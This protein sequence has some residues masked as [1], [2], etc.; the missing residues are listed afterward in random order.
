MDS[1]IVHT[2]IASAS[3]FAILVG[4][5][6]GGVVLAQA[7]AFSCLFMQLMIA[8]YSRVCSAPFV[9]L[10]ICKVFWNST[11]LMSHTWCHSRSPVLVLPSR[12]GHFPVMDAGG[13]PFPHND[14]AS[15]DAGAKDVTGTAVAGA[16][17]DPTGGNS[18]LGPTSAGSVLEHAIIPLYGMSRVP[19]SHRCHFLEDLLSVHSAISESRVNFH[20]CHSH[21][22]GVSLLFPP[23]LTS[24]QRL[25]SSASALW[26]HSLSEGSFSSSDL[27]PLVASLY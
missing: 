1:L 8:C 21:D 10:A 5:A 20:S 19:V 6:N 4:I 12:R 9:A 2:C 13:S 18:T 27:T 3:S 7:N 22:V 16:S 15:M 25:S 14:G 11:V 26:W 24:L 23:V 17:S